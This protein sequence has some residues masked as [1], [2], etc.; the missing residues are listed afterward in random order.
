MFI[1]IP[2]LSSGPFNSSSNE[3]AGNAVQCRHDAG[4]LRQRDLLGGQPH[5]EDRSGQVLLHR[6]V[7]AKRRFLGPKRELFDVQRVVAH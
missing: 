3:A 7:D 4:D 6:A 5:L 2:S 1:S